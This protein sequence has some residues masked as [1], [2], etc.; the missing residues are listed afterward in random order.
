M[1]IPRE[2]Q[3]QSHRD[4]EESETYWIM[5]IY[6]CVSETLWLIEFNDEQHAN[7]RNDLATG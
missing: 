7:N 2:D 6:L 4:T 5:L 1:V 3:P